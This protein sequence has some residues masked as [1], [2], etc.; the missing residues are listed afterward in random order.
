MLATT[1]R[2][3]VTRGRRLGDWLRERDLDLER[4]NKSCWLYNLKYDEL[5]HLKFGNAT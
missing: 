3:L 5:I 2:L 1:T 4:H